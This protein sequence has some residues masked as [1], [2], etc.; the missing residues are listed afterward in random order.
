[1]PLGEGKRKMESAAGPSKLQSLANISTILVSLLLS[2]VLVKAFLLPRPASAPVAAANLPQQPRAGMSIKDSLP[3]V[4]WGKNGQTLVLALS[5]QCH[6][7]TES[8]PFFQRIQNEASKDV[9]MVAV[10]PQTVEESRKYLETE[11]VHVDDVKQATLGSIGVRGTPTLL[12]VDNKGKVADVW[13]GK[14]DPDQ[15][16]GVLAVLKKSAP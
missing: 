15:E 14:L 7:G 4:D 6:F 1:M 3:G 16:E 9:K 8:A 10:L 12:L 13:Q 11:G 2:A 5:T